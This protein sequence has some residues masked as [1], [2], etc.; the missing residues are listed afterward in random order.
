MT[1]EARLPQI[2][3]RRH[4]LTQLEGGG[5]GEVSKKGASSSSSS[6]SPPNCFSKTW[7]E[8]CAFGE[9]QKSSN[10]LVLPMARL[11]IA[12]ALSYA[13]SVGEREPHLPQAPQVEGRGFHPQSWK[14]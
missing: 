11:H 2:M 13:I 3:S 4:G 12:S 10:L 14:N 7:L 1:R 5:G 9:S 8:K 6:S